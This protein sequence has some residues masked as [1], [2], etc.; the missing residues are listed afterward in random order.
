MELPGPTNVDIEAHICTS[1]I[2]EDAFIKMFEIDANEIMQVTNML[3]NISQVVPQT[4]DSTCMHNHTSL[5][6]LY[7][8]ILILC[9]PFY[10]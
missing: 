4:Q 6:Y 2:N 1:D 8:L 3:Y 7:R 5:E 10:I 9:T